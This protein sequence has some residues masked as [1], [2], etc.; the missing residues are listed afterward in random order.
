MCMFCLWAKGNA[1]IL[2]PSTISSYGSGRTNGNIYLEDHIGGALV[3]TIHSQSFVY[4]QGFLQPDKG[5]TSGTNVFINDVVLNDYLLLDNAGMS[6]SN[7]NVLMEFS[8]GEIQSVT[9]SNSLNHLTQGILQPHPTFRWSGIVDDNWFDTG[10]WTAGY[11]PTKLTDVL[12]PS[13]CMHYPV[14]INGQTANCR[15]VI[16]EQSAI[17]TVLSGGKLKLN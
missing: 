3:S 6:F 14:I 7:N 13:G 11:L 5:T 16:I 8:L 2:T 17:V 1:Q 15:N 9:H 4:T 12:I 10:N